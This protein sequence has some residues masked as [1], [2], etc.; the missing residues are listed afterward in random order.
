MHTDALQHDE[1]EAFARTF[2]ILG[3]AAPTIL[4]GWD[5]AELLEHLL[6]RER[7]PHL[8]VGAR[9]P[10]PLGRRAAAARAAERQQPWE[11]RVGAFRDGPGRLSPVGRID[12]LSGQGELLIHH[13]D[14][15][16]A[17]PGWTPRRLP[18]ETAADA[19]RAVGLMAP[20]AM[21]VRAEVTLVS[22]LG[23]RR[24][25]SRRAVGSL[26]VHGDPLE[27]LLWVSGRDEVAGVRIHGDQAALQALQEGRRGL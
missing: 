20:L 26:R 25:R 1:R 13:E 9:L 6:G 17:Q 16:R 14:L 7:A 8:V 18:A 12:A 15:R 11:R 4:P 3:P 2:L 10:G 27:L 19:W 24:L 21:S 23:G 22:P 5:A